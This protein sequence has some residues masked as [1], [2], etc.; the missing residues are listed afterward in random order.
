MSISVKKL[1]RKLIDKG[2][3]TD[4]FYTRDGICR[5]I[6]CTCI[7]T[8]QRFLIHVPSDYEIYVEPDEDVFELKDIDITS[9]SDNIT[10]EYEEEM[11]PIDIA[12]EYESDLPSTYSNE[13]D[14]ANTLKRQYRYKIPTEE[15]DPDNM[16]MI[17]DVFRQLDR[18]KYS[19]SSSRFSLGINYKNYLY[20]IDEDEDI[21][22]YIII[23]RGISFESKDTRQLLITINI[24]DFFEIIDT[25]SDNMETIRYGIDKILNRNYKKQI[26]LIQD[27]TNKCVASVKDFTRIAKQ[28]ADYKNAEEELK[29]LY[30]NITQSEIVALKKLS[31]RRQKSPE[32]DTGLRMLNQDVNQIEDTKMEIVNQLMLANEKVSNISLCMDKIMFDNLVLFN[33]IIS[34]FTLLKNTLSDE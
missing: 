14:I 30:K 27:M 23:N 16:R 28:N 26:N 18:L 22:V 4:K 29:T 25:A 6:D 8:G 9:I 12:N 24:E 2:F 11:K 10:Q 32:D 3:F 13:A 19:I 1:Q 15:Q 17:K 21:R 20:Y 33:S 5:T 31:D 7:A 34:N